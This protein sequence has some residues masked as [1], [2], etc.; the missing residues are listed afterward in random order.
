MLILA[1]GSATRAALLRAAGVP[2][3]IVRP[4]VDEEA[5]KRK[6]IDEGQEAP[7][8]A[9]SLAEA[10]A[11]AVSADN[12]GRLVLGADQI[13]EYDGIV[14]KSASLEA[15]RALLQRLRGVSHKLH[16]AAVFAEDGEIVERCYAE[17]GMAMRDFTGEFLD[18]YLAEEGEVILSSVGCYRLEGRGLQ[19]FSAIDGDY[20]AILGLPLLDVLT[21]L[22]QRGILS[23]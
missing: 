6:L 11:L 9:M 18:A 23:P 21:Q 19:L 20:F 14:S 13:L 8:L 16:T 1:S 22:R 15:A 5:L 17:A 3:E 2:F 10:K 12:P 7:E 4:D